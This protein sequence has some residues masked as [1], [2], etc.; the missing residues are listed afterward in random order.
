[1]AEAH[2]TLSSG[3]PLDGRRDKLVV[4]H[5]LAHVAIGRVIGIVIGRYTL[6]RQEATGT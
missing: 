3:R 6:D 5:G 1:M 2:S 4:I